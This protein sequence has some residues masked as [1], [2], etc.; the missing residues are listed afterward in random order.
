MGGGLFVVDFG[1]VGVDGVDLDG[2]G[3]FVK[4]A[5]VE[6]AA[7]RSYFKDALLLLVGAFDVFLVLNE[8]EHEEA[9]GNGAGPDEKEE[10]DEPEARPLE[11]DDAGR[12]LAVATELERSTA[13]ENPASSL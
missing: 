8:L 9:G 5:I 4:V 12:I 7:A 11:R 6:N 10:A 13:L 2:H 1:G 3:Q